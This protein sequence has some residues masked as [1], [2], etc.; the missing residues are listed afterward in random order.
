[1]N[2]TMT[3]VE[4]RLL[5]SD[6]D[7]LACFDAFLELRPHLRRDT[8]IDRVRTQQAQGY[9]I[10]AVRAGQHYPSAAGF[11]FGD[12]LAWGRVLYIDDLTTVAAARGRGHATL[13]LQWL[14]A[15][16]RTQHCDAVHLDTGHGRHDAHRLYLNQ[17]FRL[18][19]HHMSLQL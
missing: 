10:V 6:A 14:I 8:F 1:M 17:G 13:L 4:L 19:S 9:R 12:F 18:S 11:R 5:D 16:A 2:E 3:P 7:I 15:H